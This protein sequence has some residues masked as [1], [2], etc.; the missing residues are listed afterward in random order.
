[1]SIQR[2]AA[3]SDANQGQIVRALRAAGYRVWIIRRPVDLL[4]RT[5]GGWLLME[6][7]V[8]G[9]TLTDD[10]C[11]F[12]GESGMCPVAVVDEPEAA[13]RAARALEK[14]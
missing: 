4:V 9:G 7:K 5:K 14:Q 3:K 10:Q 11:T 12:L 2:W 13:I 6:V 1:M 8:P